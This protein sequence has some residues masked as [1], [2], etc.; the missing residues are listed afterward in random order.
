MKRIVWFAMAAS[1]APAAL[2]DDQLTKEIH[3]IE[4][5]C[6]PALKANLLDRTQDGQ[7]AQPIF[8][9]DPLHFN[10]QMFAPGSGSG[11]GRVTKAGSPS[12]RAGART[13]KKSWLVTCSL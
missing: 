9:G 6:A 4:N 5:Y 12:G 1:L 7:C 11:T 10:A 8:N 3:T 2:G 13:T